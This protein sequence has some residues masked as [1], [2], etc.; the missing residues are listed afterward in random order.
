MSY[1]QTNW[2]DRSVQ[3]P[4]RF[5]RTSDGTYDTLVPAPG[6]ITNGGTPLTAAAL[7]NMENG[8]FNASIVASGS[9]SNGN[10]VQY[11]NGILICWYYGNALNANLAYTLNSG[12][13][14]NYYNFGG[15]WTYPV[16]FLASKWSNISTFASGDVGGVSGVEKHGLVANS[17]GSTCNYEHGV[18]DTTNPAGIGGAYTT[19][20]YLAIGFWK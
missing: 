12:S 16:A 17:D 18:L 15:T 2:V 7:N 9:N 8:I 11:N 1:T 3:Y 10:Y 14:Y 4:Q 6:T 19:R 20:F 5:T 13:G